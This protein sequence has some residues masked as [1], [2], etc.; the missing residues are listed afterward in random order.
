MS[1]YDV[2]SPEGV[3]LL[4]ELNDKLIKEEK[5]DN[6][7]NQEILKIKQQILMKGIEISSGFR[8]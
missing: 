5:K 2:F 6:P 3:K 8:F 1:Y 7:D 4:K